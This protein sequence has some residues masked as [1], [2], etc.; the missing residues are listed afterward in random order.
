MRVLAIDGGGIRG[1]IPA[2]VL[3]E[4]ERR[5][6]RRV[7]DL[8]DRIAG[9]STGGILACALAKPDPLRAAEVAALY[10]EEGPRIFDRS[11]LKQITSLGGLLDE[12][13][14]AKGLVRALERYL[15]DT[16]MTAAT[17]P[18][19]LTAYDT[20]RRGI[21]F[22]RSEGEGSGATMVEAAHATSAAP[23][24]FEPVRLGDATLV[25]GGVF[26]INPSLCA[27]AELGGELDLLLSLGTGEHTR[28]L[29]YGEIKG[30]GQLEWARPLIDVVFDG[31]QDAVD[32]QLGALL[33]ERYVR[34]Q[35][36]LDEASDDLDDASEANLD[37]LRREAER[38]IAARDAEIDDVCERLTA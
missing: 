5:T 26:A 33:G 2:L 3:A 20:E 15:A 4:I 14:D 35:T 37:R 16:P 36:R 11:L 23:T 31:G 25:D 29:E 27:Y 12:R 18:L 22:L 1:L 32:F 9:T 38:L 7:A 30:W 13:Y 21:H 19:L 8:V 34:L 6:E 17:V 10:A 28:Q 24:Y